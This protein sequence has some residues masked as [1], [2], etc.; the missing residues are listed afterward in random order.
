[1]KTNLKKFGYWGSVITLGAV[2]GVSLQFVKAW[3]EPTATAPNGNVGAPINTGSTPQIKAGALQVNSFIVSG[4]TTATPSPAPNG[5][6]SGNMY[7]NDVYVESAGKWA[8]QMSAAALTFASATRHGCN[9]I[10][11]HGNPKYCDIGTKNM[12]FLVNMFGYDGDD[13]DGLG[14]SVEGTPGNN[15]RI[16]SVGDDY[17]QVYCEAMCI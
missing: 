1:M 7:A 6:S 3:T 9:N 5:K 14:C 8:S 10:S 16:R 17:N 15:W 2:L 13:I 4:N 11:G 12:C